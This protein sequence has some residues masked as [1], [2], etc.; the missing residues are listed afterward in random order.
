MVDDGEAPPRYALSFTSGALLAREAGIAAEL[1][2]R[3]RDWTRVR[4]LIREE[5]LLQ[6]RTGS[7]SARRAREAAHRLSVLSDAELEFL[8]DAAPSERGLLLWIAACR[9]YALI[10]DF[11]EDVVRERFLRL[12]PTLTREHFDAYLRERALWHPELAEL[13]PSTAAKLRQNVFRMLADAGLL[14]HGLIQRALPTHRLLELLRRR[15]PDDD[16]RFL[17]LAPD[18]G[19]RP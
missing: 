1:Y 7:S 14:A 11:A 10:G 13:A 6:A 3:E 15:R 9:R 12:T 4:S 2:L 19:D 18:S 16:L 5:N 17:P 8:L